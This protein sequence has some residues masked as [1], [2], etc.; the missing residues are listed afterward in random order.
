MDKFI[1]CFRQAIKFSKVHVQH[2]HVDLQFAYTCGLFNVLYLNLSCGPVERKSGFEG[3]REI[4][5]NTRNVERERERVPS[6]PLD[7]FSHPSIAILQ[8]MLPPYL[9]LPQLGSVV[10]PFVEYL[11]VKVLPSLSKVTQQQTRQELLQLL[12]EGCLY[13]I[14]D[15]SAA[16]S[17]EPVF[18]KLLVRVCVT[19]T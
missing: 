9:P 10:S 5:M 17:V 15:E 12:A 2:C 18:N 16:N 4:A 8:Y 3:K 19:C 6:H 7:I 1:S 14:S 13:T 11:S